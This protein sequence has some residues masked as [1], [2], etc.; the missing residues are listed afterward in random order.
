V[1]R[2][3]VVALAAIDLPTAAEKAAAFHPTA[4]AKDGLLDLYGAFLSRKGGAPAMAKA[5]SGKTLPPDVAKLGLRA[6]RSAVGADAGGLPD[7]LTKAGGLNA[8]TEPT[9][10]DIRARVADLATTGDAARGE[11]IFRRREMQCLACHAVGGA[12]GRVGP[13]LSSLGASAPPDYLVEALLLPN[14][15]VKEGFHAER[16]VT[17]DDKV[18]T[19]IPVREANGQLLLRTQED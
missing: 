11:A 13:D 10:D 5:L 12:G 2:Q 3:A 1:K 14:K 4:D 6:V 7:V 19:G 17:A 8:H 16:V 18:Y 15:A 9:P